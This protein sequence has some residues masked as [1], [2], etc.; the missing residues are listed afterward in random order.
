MFKNLM[1]RYYYGKA[2][3]A[4]Y[5]PD[6]LP[7]TRW[8]L[9]W[10]MLRTHPMEL[11][12]L[13]LLQLVFW[14]PAILVLFLSINAAINQIQ[15]MDMGDGVSIYNQMVEEERL[16]AQADGNEAAQP[17]REKAE[18]V[19]VADTM[20]QL[21]SL[22]TMTLLL[23]APCIAITG[24][25][26]AGVSYITRNWARS[27]HAFLWSDFKDAM[28]ENWKQSIVVS[29]LTGLIP[30]LAWISW[31]YYGEA[32]RT[33]PFM[34]IPQVVVAVAAGV[35]ALCVTY[36]H[37]LIVSYRLKLKDVLRNAL[38]L[39]IARLPMSLGI[40]LLHCVPAVIGIALFYLW[41]PIAGMFF[42]FFWYAIIGFAL[43][44]FITASFT[45]GVFDRYINSRIEGARVNRG[46]RD[47]EEDDEEEEGK[48][49]KED[50][51]ADA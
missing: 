42:L 13:N 38:L 9:F 18:V 19:S 22:V 1:N 43:S 25:G 28:K 14:I 50:R 51:T 46:M 21:T 47:P 5:T 39:G 16:Q 41:N 12:K 44:R 24:P 17:A 4:D 3:Q 23:L 26:T 27:E 8:Q 10:E 15:Y 34:A 7:A 30:L 11:V 20:R 37:P 48:E 31:L 6:D 32:S 40:R 29:L 35:W 49:A 36:M 33:Q 2:G 45:N